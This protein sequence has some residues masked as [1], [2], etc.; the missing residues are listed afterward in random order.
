MKRTAFIIILISGALMM[1]CRSGKKSDEI[2][3]YTYQEPSKK[4]NARLQEK[5][6]GWLEEGIVCYGLVVSVDGN[7]KIVKGLPVKA[8][9]VTVMSDSLKMKALEKVS[10]AEIKGCTKMGLSKGETWWE[11]EGDLFKTQEEAV[12]YL[13]SK[14]WT[15]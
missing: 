1:S 7:G 12:S 5:L 11:K 6:G 14:G 9:V 13:K 10:L 15:N 8:K 3:N 2:K 4:L